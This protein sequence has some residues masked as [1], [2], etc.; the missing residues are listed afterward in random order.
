M[1][2]VEDQEL[3]NRFRYRT[4]YSLGD[5]AMVDVYENHMLEASFAVSPICPGMLPLSNTIME[6]ST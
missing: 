2:D 3:F 1:L 6:L 5:S 4:L